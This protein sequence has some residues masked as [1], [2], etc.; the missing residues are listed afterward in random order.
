VRGFA[1]IIK[2]HRDAHDV[3]ALLLQQSGD[4]AQSTPPD[5]ATPTRLARRE[6][7]GA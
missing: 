5:M 6:G 3:I 2:L 7:C 4:D 1:V